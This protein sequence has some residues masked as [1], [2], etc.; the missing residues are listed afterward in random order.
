MSG[1]RQKCAHASR[2]WRVVIFYA[3]RGLAIAFA[4]S[5]S[6]Q[7]ALTGEQLRAA[8]RSVVKI[9]CRSTGT[10]DGHAATGFLWGQTNTVVT[11][12]HVVAGCN[13][14]TVYFEASGAKRRATIS[15]VRKRADL[16]LLEVENPPTLPALQSANGAPQVNDEFVVLGYPLNI[17][18]LNSTSLRLRYGGKRLK[19]IVPAKVADT[20]RRNGYPDVEAQIINLEG[21]LL[22]GLSGAPILD[23]AGRV[24][25]VA[26]GGLEN[27]A[28]AISWGL[29]VSELQPLVTSTESVHPREG[30][31]VA[32]L[33]AADLQLSVGETINCGVAK[34][35]KI[36][37][38]SF[39]DLAQSSDDPQGLLHLSASIGFVNATFEYDIYQHSESGATIVVPAGVTLTPS[40][41]MC[42]A[43]LANGQI[44]LK[45]QIIQVGSPYEIQNACLMY[46][47]LVMPS[48]FQNQWQVDPY[49]SYKMPI[50]R[51]DGLSVVR[52]GV[53]KYVYDW[54][55]NLVPEKYLFETL[56]S[57]G[58]TVIGYSVT[59]HDRTPQTRQHEN[60]CAQG[61]V[62]PQCP[63][64]SAAQRDWARMLLAAHLTS[65]SL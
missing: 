32:N 37:T 30:M 29:P 3:L 1:I 22:P 53:N 65:F 23:A 25:A 34:L 49:W 52:R 27:G 54:T 40:G 9:E 46:E 14:I 5:L 45:I 55:Y 7:P 61:Y 16:A 4:S 8:S 51:F 63:Q 28:V 20:I 47:A 6:A 17:P 36:R 33:F 48:Q 59:N 24:V 62:L 44:E 12:L 18:S 26:D 19:D 2:Q 15:R 21:H 60:W 41:D 43:S 13:N 31:I 42:I 50:S 10:E 64:I 58:N 56:A 35:T 39:L 11:A 57:R 38:R